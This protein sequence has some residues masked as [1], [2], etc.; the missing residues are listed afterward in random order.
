MK[1]CNENG[2]G[3]ELVHAKKYRIMHGQCKTQTRHNNKQV[4]KKQS[5]N[6][7]ETKVKRIG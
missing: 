6:L 2:R 5:R 4:K 3:G 7:C 1:K